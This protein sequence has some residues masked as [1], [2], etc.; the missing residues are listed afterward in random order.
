VEVAVW[1]VGDGLVHGL[2]LVAQGVDIDARH[3][4]LSLDQ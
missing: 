1:F 2:D 3:A 4:G